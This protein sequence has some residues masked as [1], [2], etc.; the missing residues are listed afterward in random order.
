MSRR[1]PTDACELDERT[2]ELLVRDAVRGLSWFIPTS[3]DEVEAWEAK[4]LSD[5]SDLP[6]ASL[7]PLAVLRG[8]LLPSR[9]QDCSPADASYQ[10]ELRR[11][12]R[13]LHGSISADIE[14]RMQHDREMAQARKRA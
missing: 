5:A 13:E 9:P 14:V 2:L 4:L 3:E 10:E 11:A 1:K 7:D 6:R 12:A 8:Q